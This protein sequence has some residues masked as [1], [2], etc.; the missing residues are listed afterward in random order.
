MTYAERLIRYAKEKR[1]LDAKALTAKE[2]EVEVKKL[3]E[4]WRI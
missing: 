2:H 4:K 1:E 3:A